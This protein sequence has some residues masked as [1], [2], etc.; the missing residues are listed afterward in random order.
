M[1][2][3]IFCGEVIEA[4]PS[5]VG[6]GRDGSILKDGFLFQCENNSC[7]AIYESIGIKVPDIKIINRPSSRIEE[8]DFDGG[9][10]E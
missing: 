8:L 10:E 2:R 5:L 1:H 3:C 9:E 4:E 6:T 7:C